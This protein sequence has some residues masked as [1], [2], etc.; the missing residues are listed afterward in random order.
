LIID[1]NLD[2]LMKLADRHYV[3]ENGKVVWFGT[4]D[5]NANN[6]ALK[7]RYLGV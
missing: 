6:E 4:T 1:K 7:T 5:K 2:A 3:M